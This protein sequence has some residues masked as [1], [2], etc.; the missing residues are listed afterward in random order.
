VS[1]QALYRT[2]KVGIMKRL[3]NPKTNSSIPEWALELMNTRGINVN[4]VVAWDWVTFK[5]EA[6]LLDVGEN[7]G[8]LV[9]RNV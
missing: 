8:I 4:D 7:W 6:I 9:R 3:A 5:E 1:D 2:S